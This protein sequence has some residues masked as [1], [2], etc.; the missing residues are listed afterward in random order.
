MSKPIVFVDTNKVENKGSATSF[1]GGRSELEKIAKRADIAVPR[2]VYDELCKHIT[3]YL[4]GQR[5]SFRRNPYRH[6]LGIDDEGINTISHD[7]LISTLVQTEA[8]SYEVVDLEDES[9]A[10]KEIYIHAIDGTAPFEPKGDKGFKDSLIAKTI[11]QYVELYSDR[12]VFL[13]TGDGRLKEYFADNSSV[14]AIEDFADFDREYSE[15]KMEESWLQDRVRDY[16][17]EEWILFGEPATNMKD[18]WLSIDD[19]IVCV[20]RHSD[21]KDVYV[22][23]NASAREPESYTYIPVRQIVKELSKVSSFQGAHNAIASVSEVLAYLS[24]EDTEQVAR[25]MID[26]S[27][28]Y[29]ISGDD[30]IA[31]FAARMFSMLDENGYSALAKEVNDRYGLKLLTSMQLAELPF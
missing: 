31:E 27:Q 16:L 1:F 4:S 23:V 25:S 30:D 19:N 20:F 21:D 17:G 7:D 12:T 28:I 22:L 3:G 11:D 14:T 15:D 10:Y 5:D 29:G 24:A 2:V 9:R 13:L 6:I 18:Q 8:I 26:N